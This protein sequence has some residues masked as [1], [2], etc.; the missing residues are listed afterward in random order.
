MM[1]YAKFDVLAD[2][3]REKTICVAFD[4]ETRATQ[5]YSLVL[6]DMQQHNILVTVIV[7]NARLNEASVRAIA[8]DFLLGKLAIS[9]GFFNTQ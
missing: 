7:K 9:D 8:Q 5:V 4:E 2:M 3:P 6:T 1:K